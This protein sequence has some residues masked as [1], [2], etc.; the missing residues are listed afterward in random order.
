MQYRQLGDTGLI[1]SRLSFGAMTFTN[2]VAS[3]VAKTDRANANALLGRAL[4]AGVNLFDTADVYAQGQS[5]EI[6]GAFVRSR[7][8]EVV[9]STKTGFR[10]GSGLHQAGL[11]RK[12]LLSACEASLKRLG[13]DYIDVYSPHIADAFTPL[14]ETLQALDDLVRQGKTRYI[15]C[16][17]W[18]AWRMAKA[19]QM[20]K[21]RGWARFISAQMY[22]SLLGRELEQEYV[23]MMQDA[24]MGLMAWSPLAGGFL[25]GKYTPQNLKDPS[26]RLSGFDVIPF[27]KDMGFRVVDKLREIGLR[28][29]NAGPAQVALVWLLAQ[30]FA[31]TILLGASKMEQLEDNLGA[32]SLTLSPNDLAALNEM[33]YL[34]PL[35]LNSIAAHAQ[36]EQTK[37]ALSSR[38]K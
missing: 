2:G 30:P 8:E 37:Q 10:A 11:S 16:S 3:A 31:T 5:E 29:D 20:Q 32:A 33:T 17:N 24:G 6:L 28:H 38:T 4:D 15:G 21:E 13:T 14:E 25:S 27:D 35:F 7:R 36:D 18:P 26:N 1:V 12:R 22:Y 23:P 19:V 9:I 34:P